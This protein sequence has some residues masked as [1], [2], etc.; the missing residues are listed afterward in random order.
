MGERKVLASDDVF[1]VWEDLKRDGFGY[2]FQLIEL[3]KAVLEHLGHPTT[4]H[5]SV[6]VNQRSDLVE[7]V[8]VLN[9]LGFR[10]L[11]YFLLSFS[12]G[13]DALVADTL[14]SC[15]NWKTAGLWMLGT[16]QTP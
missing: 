3:Q 5:A 16:A 8:D 14:M 1:G 6:P 13:A 2:C 12:H 4:R 7:E 11:F 9:K 15:S 10:S